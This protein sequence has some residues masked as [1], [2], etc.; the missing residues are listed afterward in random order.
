MKGKEKH[1]KQLYLLV[2][3]K[4]QEAM[5]NE[6]SQPGNVHIIGTGR[7]PDE[8]AKP[9]RILIIIIGLIAGLGGAFG[10]YINKRLFR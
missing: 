8:P 4:Y 9:N 10:F 3:Q 5:I 7:I 6:L 2:D 1:L